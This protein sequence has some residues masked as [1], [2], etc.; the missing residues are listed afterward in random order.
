MPRRS[1]T[2]GRK[3]SISASV[4]GRPLGVAAADRLG[5]VDAE[6]L[7]AHVAQQHGCEGAG[8]DACDFDDADAVERSG[9][10]YLL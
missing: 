5:A 2:P 7:G 10:V 4:E 6:H 1:A 8:A 9:H 3:P